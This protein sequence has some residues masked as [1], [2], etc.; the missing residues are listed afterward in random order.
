MRFSSGSFVVGEV[1]APVESRREDR[2]TGVGKTI[3]DKLAQTRSTEVMVAALCHP[4]A[5]LRD[6]A[7]T[8]IEKFRMPKSELVVK[9][10]ELLQ[11][12]ACYRSA[13]ELA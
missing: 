5:E 9:L 13:F 3:M 2:S 11:A 8:E 4:C 1:R 10:L 7:L 12:E 6:L